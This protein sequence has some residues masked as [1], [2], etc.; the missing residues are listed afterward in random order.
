M[1]LGW[2]DRPARLARFVLV[3]TAVSLALA[4]AA[5]DDAPRR[6]L[7]PGQMRSLERATDAVL[8][9]QVRAVDDARSARTLGHEREGSGIV[10]DRDGLVLTIGYLVLEADALW[11][12]PDDGRRIPARVV[13]YDLA[14]GFGLV[15]PLV[16]LG[17]EPA[18]LGPSGESVPGE[19]LVV[20]S[21]GV[22]GQVSLAWLVSRRPFAGYWEYAIDGALF[23][24]PPRRDHSGAGLFNARGELIGVGSL[25]V[26]DA[27]MPGQ[28]GTP[29]NMFVPTDLLRPILGELLE[30]GR[31]AASE[32]AW[33]GINCAERDG[34]VIVLRISEDSPAEQAGLQRGDRI[35]AIDGTA[36][37]NLAA[38]WRTLWAGG[39]PQRAVALQ[40]RRDGQTRDL[41][42][43]AIDRTTALRRAEGI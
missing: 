27:A 3:A 22:D 12:L 10:I 6:S 25:V 38:L 37:T 19:P 16:P 31:S 7:D 34:Q 42:V 8:G 14:T 20:A 35:V 4:A 23:T 32:R 18:P 13:A 41:V 36:V 15:R 29:G 28:P 9:L 1:T 5:A 43:H 2:L 30:R 26:G 24:A 39:A 33:L 11:L 21:G 40:I 17:I